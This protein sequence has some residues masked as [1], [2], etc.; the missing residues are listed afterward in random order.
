MLHRERVS[1]AILEAWALWR[2][3]NLCLRVLME[4]PKHWEFVGALL[5]AL[6]LRQ[7]EGL[8]LKAFFCSVFPY[9]SLKLSCNPLCSPEQEKVRFFCIS[10]SINTKIHSSPARSS[11]K[12]SWTKIWKKRSYDIFEQIWR[13]PKKKSSHSNHYSSIRGQHHNNSK[14]F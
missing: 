8:V 6:G 10:L 1:T 13:Q 12:K 11:K 3:R 5:Q 7:V 14:A 2:Q 9:T 4:D